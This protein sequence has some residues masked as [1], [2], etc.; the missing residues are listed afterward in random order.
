MPTNKQHSTDLGQAKHELYE[1]LKLEQSVAMHGARSCEATAIPQP[2][3]CYE[4]QVSLG[5]GGK[6]VTLRIKHHVRPRQ[7]T[8]LAALLVCVKRLGL[9][10]V[11]VLLVP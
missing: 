6:L 7:F 3:G 2:N 8:T 11:K 1:L 9:R 4:L 5:T 10:E